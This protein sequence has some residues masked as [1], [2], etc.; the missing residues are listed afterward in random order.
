MK[1][2]TI[3]LALTTFIV[4]SCGLI[5]QKVE[6]N[7]VRIEYSKDVTKEDATKLVDYL[8]SNNEDGTTKDFKL[9][10][11]GEGFKIKMVTRAGFT[12]DDKN[13]E[14][15]TDFACEI[16]KSVFG[17]KSVVLELCTDTWVLE[18]SLNTENC[19]E[20]EMAGKESR[21]FGEVELFY[22]ES[23]S[24]QQQKDVGAYLTDYF[25]RD[26]A[27]TFVIDKVDGNGVLSIVVTDKRYY[28]EEEKL[29][30]YRVIACDLTKIL[31]FTTNVHMCDEYM[32]KQ[33]EV[34]P[35]KCDQ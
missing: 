30:I 34:S 18:K 27:R 32:K 22:G 9:S 6:K 3:V 21:M 14:L 24:E 28:E 1:K 17:G 10:K 11:E 12:T 29:D 31:G 13:L 26:V 15:M 23:I 7:G 19:D 2:I 4:A 20:F 8:A 35:S 33:K 25:G 5:P 16:S